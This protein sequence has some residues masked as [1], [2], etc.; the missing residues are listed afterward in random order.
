MPYRQDAYPE[1]VLAG[2]N[3]V[4]GIQLREDNSGTRHPAG[5]QLMTAMAQRFQFLTAMDSKFSD[6]CF[7]ISIFVFGLFSYKNH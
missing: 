7:C 4:G 1:S 3:G 6:F 2:I 5:G